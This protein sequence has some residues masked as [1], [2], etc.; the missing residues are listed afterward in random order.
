[1]GL[2]DQ[3]SFDRAV[4]GGCPACGAKAVEI[5]SFLDRSVAVMLAE[6]TDAGRWAHDGEQFVDGTYRIACTACKHVV[7]ESDACPRCN[8]AGG[9]ARALGEENRLAVPKRCP[10]C[11]E[12]ELLALAMVPAVA[13]YGG[14]EAPKPAPLAEWGEAGYHVVAFACDACNRAVVAEGCPLCA[15]PGPLRAR[16]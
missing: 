13:R 14:G 7:F 1:M 16:P 4:R 8:A 5:R 6:P 3:A 12:L 11:S 2:L 9:L 15:A 10:G